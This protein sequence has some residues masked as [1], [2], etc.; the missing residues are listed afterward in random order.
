MYRHVYALFGACLYLFRCLE[1]LGETRKPSKRLN[2]LKH[3]LNTP[4]HSKHF[5][6][7]L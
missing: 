4:K 5:G 7:A 6:G 2:T 3:G 1:R